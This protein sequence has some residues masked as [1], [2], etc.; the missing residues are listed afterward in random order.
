MSG[1]VTAVHECADCNTVTP[2]SR[3]ADAGCDGPVLYVDGKWICGRCGD[4]IAA[5]ARCRECGSDTIVKRR[6]VPLDVSPDVA[7]TA[8]EQAVHAE[9]NEIRDRESLPA[10]GLDRHLAGIAR[11]HSRRMATNGFFSHE[12]PDGDTVADRYDAWDYSWRRCGENIAARH[13]TSLRDAR[14]IAREVVDGWLHSDG[15]RENLLDPDW[16]VEGIGVYYAT[17]GS[18]YTTQNFA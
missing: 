1:V 15:H 6:D 4:P 9:V 14:A 17:D 5:T 3:H 13:P 16:N 8:V 18:V 11:E 12:S 10:L 2:L 7:P